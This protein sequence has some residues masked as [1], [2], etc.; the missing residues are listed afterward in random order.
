MES[1]PPAPRY[2]HAILPWPVELSNLSPGTTAAELCTALAS[3]GNITHSFL[4]VSKMANLGAIVHFSDHRTA[5]AAAA[6][7]DGTC[8]DGFIL[9]ARLMSHKEQFTFSCHL[10][11]PPPPR[12]KFGGG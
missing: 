2:F 9:Q 10:S 7:L 1:T 4:L 6:D 11:P 12:C 3:Y 8:A 5:A